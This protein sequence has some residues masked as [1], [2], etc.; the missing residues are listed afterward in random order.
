MGGDSFEI[1][2]YASDGRASGRRGWMMV[3]FG[4]VIVGLLLGMSITGFSA[5][6]AP[7]SFGD[8]EYEKVPVIRVSKPVGTILAAMTGIIIGI[9]AG[10]LARRHPLL[11]ALAG[12]L[13]S[14]QALSRPLHFFSGIVAA[15]PSVR[16]T[17][18][19]SPLLPLWRFSF[20][21]RPLSP[22]KCSPSPRRFVIER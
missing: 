22:H 10:R 14:R 4:G 12:S 9:A 17:E 16:S 13:F 18:G 21:P 7:P 15:G 1:L 6:A 20:A 2:E 11:L 8:P 5:G 19:S 3:L